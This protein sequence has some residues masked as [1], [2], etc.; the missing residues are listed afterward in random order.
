[1]CPAPQQ[2]IAKTDVGM[3]QPP[4]VKAEDEVEDSLGSDLDRLL[5][6]NTRSGSGRDGP[7][8]NADMPQ[9][10]DHSRPEAVAMYIIPT[11][12]DRFMV[13]MPMLTTFLA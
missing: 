4:L 10:L 13:A 8:P 2:R 12:S 9:R 1:M 6:R 5:P 7:G 3:V 11:Q